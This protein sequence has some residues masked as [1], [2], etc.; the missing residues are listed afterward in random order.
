MPNGTWHS[1]VYLETAENGRLV[2]INTT[3][4]TKTSMTPARFS[5]MFA[6]FPK[7]ESPYVLE[8]HYPT[9]AIQEQETKRIDDQRRAE[10]DKAKSDAAFSDLLKT[11]KTL[12]LDVECTVNRKL[13]INVRN[14]AAEIE[15]ANNFNLYTAD[16][17]IKIADIL[18]QTPYALPAFCN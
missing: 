9:P 4:G 8:D 3:Y 10:E 18:K 2:F 6:K 5:F 13:G 11:L 16:I 14:I 7:T 1:F 17:V 12:P 15:S